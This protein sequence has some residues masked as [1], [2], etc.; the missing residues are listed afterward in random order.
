MLVGTQIEVFWEHSSD[1]EAHED[2]P[3]GWY[4]CR[5]DGVNRTKVDGSVKTLLQVR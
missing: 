2:W 3:E 1:P 5:V 4:R